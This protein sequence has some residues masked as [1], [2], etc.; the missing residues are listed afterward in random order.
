MR[1]TVIDDRDH[2]FWGRITE[3][4]G[5]N[6]FFQCI[7]CGVTCL[8]AMLSLVFVG[9]A[10]TMLVTLVEVP[11]QAAYSDSDSWNLG[12]SVFAIVGCPMLVCMENEHAQRI[13][14]V[15]L[16]FTTVCGLAFSSSIGEDDAFKNLRGVYCTF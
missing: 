15:G 14:F 7:A 6:L 2:P 11:V 5:L 4:S 12:V 9:L 10:F 1:S 13:V 8:L 3:F 16:A